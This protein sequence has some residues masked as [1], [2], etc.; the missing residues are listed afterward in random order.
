MGASHG[1]KR[2][3]MVV[4]KSNLIVMS[5]APSDDDENSQIK[6]VCSYHNAHVLFR[7]DLDDSGI[8]RLRVGL[9]SL[10]FCKGKIG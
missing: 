1:K 9:P 4:G 6:Y 10:V 5:E 3:R 7:G 2:K 8:S